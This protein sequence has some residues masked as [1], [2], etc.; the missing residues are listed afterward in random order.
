MDIQFRF[1][2]DYSVQHLLTFIDDTVGDLEDL[3]VKVGN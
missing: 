1:I 3:S 2:S